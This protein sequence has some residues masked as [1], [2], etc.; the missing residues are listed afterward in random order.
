MVGSPFSSCNARLP[1]RRSG[2]TAASHG[3]MRGSSITSIR[4]VAARMA[5]AVAPAAGHL[6]ARHDLLERVERE[7]AVAMLVLET[8]A[9]LS[10]STADTRAAPGRSIGIPTPSPPR[11][12]VQQPACSRRRLAGG[13]HFHAD[14]HAVQRHAADERFR[15]VDRVDDPAVALVRGLRGCRLPRRGSSA[16]GSDSEPSPGS[17]PRLRDRRR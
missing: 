11:Q 6:R 14:Q 4:P 16:S 9:S 8:T 5:V 10:L 2:G 12:F 13:H 3:F 15:A 7:I 1:R 17:S